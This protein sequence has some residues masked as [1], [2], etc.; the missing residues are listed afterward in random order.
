M[1]P[2]NILLRGKGK[3]KIQ[4]LTSETGFTKECKIP[5]LSGLYQQLLYYRELPSTGN[6]TLTPN[7]LCHASN[8][9]NLLFLNILL[10]SSTAETVTR[11]IS[12]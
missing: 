7:F 9:E 8:S 2:V 5:E 1:N 10:I 3:N 4:T 6:S 11:L 12:D